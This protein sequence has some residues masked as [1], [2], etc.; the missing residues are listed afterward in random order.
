[1]EHDL[2]IQ[3][4]SLITRRH[5]ET[6]RRLARMEK[7]PGAYKIGGRWMI[8]QEAADKLRNIPADLNRLG[9]DRE[10]PIQLE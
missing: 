10:N 3:E 1:M 6:L 7:L 8:S 2:T 5:V 9:L 4:F